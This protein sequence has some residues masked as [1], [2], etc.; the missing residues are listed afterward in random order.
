MTTTIE[1][2]FGSRDHGARLPLNNELTDFRLR[3]GGANQVRRRQA[4]A[5]QQQR[6]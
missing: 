4:A 1:A 5:Q 6:R 3:A 2:S